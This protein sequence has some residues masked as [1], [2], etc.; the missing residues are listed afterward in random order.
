MEAAIYKEN[1]GFLSS[2]HEGFLEIPQVAVIF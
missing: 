1:G 2:S